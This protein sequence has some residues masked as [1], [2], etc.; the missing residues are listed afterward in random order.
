MNGIDPLRIATSMS[1]NK[2]KTYWKNISKEINQIFS[3]M[4]GLILIANDSFLFQDAADFLDKINRFNER[5]ILYF[6]FN[7]SFEKI[8]DAVNKDSFDFKKI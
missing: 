1:S 2:N 4:Q 6:S 7:T 3:E 8:K 5:K